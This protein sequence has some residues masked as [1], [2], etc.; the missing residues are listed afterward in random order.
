VEEQIDAKSID[1]LITVH[2]D[3]VEDESGK[4]L[5]CTLSVPFKMSKSM[6]KIA[7]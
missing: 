7:S 1:S 5:A 3:P 6:Q 4:F 2:F